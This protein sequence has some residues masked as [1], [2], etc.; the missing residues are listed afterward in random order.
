M[1]KSLKEFLNQPV[2]LRQPTA[3]DLALEALLNS[4]DIYTSASTPAPLLPAGTFTREEAL[5]VT[6]Y[7]SNVTIENDQS[8]HFQ[9]VVRN[10]N[11]QLIERVWN[12]QTDAGQVLNNYLKTH[13]KA[14]RQ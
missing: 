2:S 7:Y 11:G 3:E 5:T 13:G 8:A 14:V 1:C 4:G 12:F 10:A 9:L 6:A